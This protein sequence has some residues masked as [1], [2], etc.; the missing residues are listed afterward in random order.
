MLIRYDITDFIFDDLRDSIARHDVVDQR[1]IPRTRIIETARDRFT[2]ESE[3]ATREKQI[4][5]T[6]YT[7]RPSSFNEA[8]TQVQ[9]RR[10]HVGAST[11]ITVTVSVS[12]L[13]FEQHQH[14]PGEHPPSK[15]QPPGGHGHK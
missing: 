12:D 5:R 11:P 7:D 4:T 1:V 15:G 2:K 10:F 14:L 6:D 3:K 9:D 13:H 8:V